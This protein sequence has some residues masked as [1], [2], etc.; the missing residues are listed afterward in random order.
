[1]LC[2][3]KRSQVAQTSLELVTQVPVLLLLPPKCWD[4]TCVCRAAKSLHSPD[5]ESAQSLSVGGNLRPWHATVLGP[6][7]TLP[8]SLP[9][10]PVLPSLPQPDSVRSSICSELKP[11]TS[12]HQQL[13]AHIWLFYHSPKH[14]CSI[15]NSQLLSFYGETILYLLGTT[16]MLACLTKYHSCF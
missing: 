16:S 4:Y 8:I 5:A 2:F 6:C 9:T 3:E 15:T 14:P 10:I 12:C 11:L 1:M 13:E 7:Q